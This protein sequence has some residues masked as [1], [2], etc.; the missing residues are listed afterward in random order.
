MSKSPIHLRTKVHL[1]RQDTETL[2][3]PACAQMVLQAVGGDAVDQAGLAS[4]FSSPAPWGMT[5]EVL[6]TSITF[7][8]ASPPCYVERAYSTRAEAVRAMARSLFTHKRP[9]IALVSG[10]DHWVVVSEMRGT[11]DSKANRKKQ[12]AITSVS[13][14]DPYPDLKYLRDANLLPDDDVSPPP[15]KRNDICS[16]VGHPEEVWSLDDW[17]RDEFTACR[18]KGTWKGKWV[19]VC[20]PADEA[21]DM[22]SAFAVTTPALVPTRHRAGAGRLVETPSKDS[23]DAT[24]IRWAK[25]QLGALELGRQQAWTRI[26]RNDA[27]C[28]RRD[29]QGLEQTS[30]YI[31]AS[32][33]AGSHGRLLLRFETGT[34]R[35][36]HAARNPLPAM[37]DNLALAHAGSSELAW[38]RC[39]ETRSP[40][41]PLHVDGPDRYRLFNRM[42]SRLT[43]PWSPEQ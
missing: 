24:V 36:V 5:P 2:C 7:S 42:H 12:P 43:P 30:S 15:H 10:G 35:L 27:V 21:C 20:P 14:C 34:W 22:T 25:H 31:L 26:L 6:A 23:D 32:V 29:V 28:K 39:A 9:A 41:L 19:V 17:G 11:F 40:L 4:T 8:Q 37:F 18:T 3:G 16:T 13:V 33:D 38:T 1:H